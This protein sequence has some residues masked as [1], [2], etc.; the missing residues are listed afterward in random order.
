MQEPA[1]EDGQETGPGGVKAT[2]VSCKPRAKKRKTNDDIA[3][4]AKQCLDEINGLSTETDKS[5]EDDDGIYGKYVSS[6]MRKINNELVKQIV[7]GEI[8]NI[9]LRAHLGHFEAELNVRVN[10]QHFS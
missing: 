6:E 9:F 1:V 5:E 7:K 4:I 2:P 10:R 3:D 8:Q